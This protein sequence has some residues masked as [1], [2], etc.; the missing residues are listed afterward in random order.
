MSFNQL[1][2]KMAKAHSE[3]YLLYFLCNSFAVMFFFMFATVFFNEEV[4]AVKKTESIQYV[5]TIP[6]VALLV[7]TIFFIRYAHQIFI[8]RR[9][10]ELG[11]FKTL[12]MTNGD[13]TKLLVI[14]NGV[15]AFFAILLGLLSGL[16]FSRLF[17]MM[18]MKGVGLQE[19]SFHVN[20]EMLVYPVLSFLVIFITGISASLFAILKGE[21]I[22]HIN[23]DKQAETL[24]M[25]YPLLGGIGFLMLTGS[26]LGLYMTYQQSDGGEY[27]LL[28]SALT[29]IG[30]Y[31]CISQFSSLLIDWMKK[32]KPLYYRRLL[33]F[34]SL[35][36]KFNRLA[37]ILMLVTVMI[38][39]TILY[40]TLILS[41]YSLKEQQVLDF[42]PYDI[43]FIQS[44]DTKQLTTSE[45]QSI[46]DNH[47]DS[48][49]KHLILPVFTYY[50]MEGST[51]SASRYSFM[52]QDQYNQLSSENIDLNDG[53]YLYF[54]NQEPEF[55]GDERGY[56][57]QLPSSIQESYT[58][59]ETIID[60]K[61]NLIANMSE[62]YI[63]TKA[64]F[65][66]LTQTLD[67]LTFSLH[68]INTD[69]WK[70]TENV[71]KTIEYRLL[72]NRHD[73]HTEKPL[74]DVS[75]K[76]E[77]HQANKTSNG[78]L[79]FVSSFLSVIFFIGSF[80]LLYLNLFSEIDKE[81]RKYEKLYRIGM[82]PKEIKQHISREMKVIFF[83]P[84]I[85]G[86]VLAFLYVVAMATDVGGILA[87]PEIFL[88]F[89]CVTAI[90]HVI[91]IGF[92]SY[93]RNKMYR[94]LSE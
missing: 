81:K 19:I 66:K 62:L 65:Q 49:T 70:R 18:L 7:F 21:L 33:L 83:L 43:A 37:A 15:I 46:L 87:N 20:Q 41:T 69:D 40:S 84:T 52:S 28:W 90:Y 38:M 48:I 86:T 75:S 91:Q 31:V 6:G 63:V 9:K 24:K 16:V 17:F 26:I 1:A 61:I 13:L 55:A 51:E 50:E 82:T 22:N 58:L 23:S 60:R 8:K 11:L 71:V 34:T 4:V 67:G 3:K 25:K 36:Y 92:F 54:I 29:F 10:S 56:N 93:T 64:E 14:E 80:V 77:D 59:K 68:L 47:N 72:D 42:N 79:F 2:W 88:F 32:F 85:F 39:I 45:I 12:G 76:V 89:L 57:E 27:L 35:E 30:L 94:I 53:E 44:E 5:L 73:E 78:I 74:F